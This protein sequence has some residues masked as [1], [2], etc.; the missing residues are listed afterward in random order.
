MAPIEDMP[1]QCATLTVDGSLLFLQDSPFRF[2]SG[3]QRINTTLHWGACFELNR[4]ESFA[5]LMSNEL[6]SECQ[7]VILTSE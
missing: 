2:I 3:S 1:I 7:E 4:V 6:T 5:R